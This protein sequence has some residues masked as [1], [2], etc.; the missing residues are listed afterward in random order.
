MSKCVGGGG[1]GRASATCARTS[2]LGT[3]RSTLGRWD[4]DPERL[5][6]VRLFCFVSRVLSHAGVVLLGIRQLELQV[7]SFSLGTFLHCT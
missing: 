7:N 5:C 6:L 4:G 3:S 2:T 1:A